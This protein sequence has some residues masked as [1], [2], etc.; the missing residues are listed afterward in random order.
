MIGSMTMATNTTSIDQP[1]V[2]EPADVG[3]NRADRDTA[4]LPQLEPEMRLYRTPGQEFEALT[5]EIEG[6]AGSIR[7]VD[8]RAAERLSD[9]SSALGTED[10][11]TR[12]ADVD[13]RRAFNTERIAHAWAVRKEGG[14]AS[15]AIETI[16]RVRNVL[17]L[18][19]LL[20][21]WFAFYEASR[22]YDR[23]LSA[24]PE[25]AGQ[26]LLV[27][28]Q[29]GFGGELPAWSRFSSVALIDAAIIGLIILMTFISEG[30]REKREDE[31]LMSANRFQT[32]LDN[33]LGSATVVLAPDRANR[34]AVLAQNVERLA[35]RFDRNSQ[36]L[37]NRLQVEHD[38]LELVAGRREQEF[39]DF[40]VFA[41]GMRSGA[42][43]THRLLID[44]RQV[45]ISLQNAL[46]D[47]TSE[48]G[49]S[50][51]QQRT[52]L[53]AVGNLE[54]LVASGIQ[55]DQT[56]TRQLSDAANNLADAADRALSGSEQAAQAGRMAGEA[57]RG[58][59]EIAAM[60]AESQTR[61]EG[62]VARE[63]DSTSRLA[64]T[65]RS[66]LAGIS[67]SSSQLNDISHI[68][69][70][71]RDEFAHLSGHQ[72]DQTSRL[73]AMLESE[74][75]VAGQLAQVSRDLGAAGLSVGQ[76]ERELKAELGH[77]MQQVGTVTQTLDRFAHQLPTTEALQHAFATALR[78]ELTGQAPRL[79]PQPN[80]GQYPP[81]RRPE[82]MGQGRPQSEDRGGWRD[83][84]RRPGT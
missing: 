49:V 80:G 32:D 40:A 16:S 83:P 58:I 72:A 65:L 73:A 2:R 82:P 39:S 7:E 55:S 60:L 24:N 78:Q 63:A 3:R 61:V 76:R 64:E 11:R 15:A 17:V 10:S 42:E 46:E 79:A 4:A 33:V 68:L 30:R 28:W 8:A 57:V 56:V 47:M 18:V 36:E 26:P 59:A 75:G 44:L 34:T 43:E 48:V 6:L 53:Q 74:T 67:G 5:N 45:S 71:L 13:L 52:L 37:L 69:A 22:A 9:L 20:V 23:Y 50:G 1:T 35:L 19:P 12:W 66:S 38:R 51:D 77:L 62:S 54:R 29:R 21:T 27:L 25:E 41:S 14:Y 70:G 31:I 81:Q 84:N